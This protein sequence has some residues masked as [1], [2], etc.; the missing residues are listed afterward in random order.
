MC[1]RNLDFVRK[2]SSET[3]IMRTV[4]KISSP[5]MRNG[6]NVHVNDLKRYGRSKVPI[7]QKMVLCNSTCLIHC[8]EPLMA[9]SIIFIAMN[10]TTWRRK[11]VHV[12][13]FYVLHYSRVFVL[14][15]C[16]RATENLGSVFLTMFLIPFLFSGMP[17]TSSSMHGSL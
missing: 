14:A 13:N 11:F 15:W 9:V 6:I 5:K 4:T 3:T 17:T 7:D 10:A 1:W 2:S 8:S 12:V 16:I